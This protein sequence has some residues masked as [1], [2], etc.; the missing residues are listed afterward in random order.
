MLVTYPPES[1]ASR[2]PAWAVP[3][4]H[5]D[6]GDAGTSWRRSSTTEHAQVRSGVH[7]LDNRAHRA[8]RPFEWTPMAAWV[9]GREAVASQSVYCVLVRGGSSPFRTVT[10]LSD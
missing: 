8:R 6:D 9:S 5:Y 10:T 4:D 2:Q 7:K 1:S 3:A